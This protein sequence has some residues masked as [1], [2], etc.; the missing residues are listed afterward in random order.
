[1]V[2]L[3]QAVDTPHVKEWL[4]PIG[5]LV[6]NF[7]AIEIQSYLWLGDALT[8]QHLF[9][10][11]VDWPF[12]RRVERILSVIDAQVTDPAVAEQC[13]A[14]WSTALEAAMFRNS[15]LHNPIVFGWVSKSEE[16]PP[17]FIGVPDVGHLG[18]KPKS[19]QKIATLAE[20]K[21]RINESAATAGSL[22][23]TRSQFKAFVSEQS[24]A[25]QGVQRDG[26]AAR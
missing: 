17:D 1:M 22:F 9:P 6:L 14:A 20:I 13:K 11:A 18:A 21:R 7:S 23:A 15:I 25:Q 5:K 10:A 2:Q 4:E 16:G 12:K 26:F 3:K 24:A 19:T 8:E